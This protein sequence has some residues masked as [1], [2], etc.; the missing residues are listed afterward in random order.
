[1][2]AP[3]AIL[4]ISPH[5]AAVMQSE[6]HSRSSSTMA[7]AGESTPSGAPAERQS[8]QLSKSTLKGLECQFYGSN[9]FDTF[10]PDPSKHKFCLEGKTSACVRA[11]ARALLAARRR[12]VTLCSQIRAGSGSSRE[13]LQAGR[14]FPFRLRAL[15]PREVRVRA[16]DHANE[17]ASRKGI[18]LARRYFDKH[19]PQGMRRPKCKVPPLPSLTP[20]SQHDA[21]CR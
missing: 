9:T 21:R 5:R 18:T 1:M 6:S 15:G 20:L 10:Y 19:L 11:R 13:H 2:P 8:I 4:K 12:R 16:A 14:P 17:R 7:A 3:P